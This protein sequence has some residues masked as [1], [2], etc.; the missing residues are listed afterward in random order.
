M[1]LPAQIQQFEEIPPK[2]EGDTPLLRIVAID[3]SLP[4]AA[5]CTTPFEFFIG[6]KGREKLPKGD[7]TDMNVTILIKEMKQGRVG[8]QCRGE[9]VKAGPFETTAPAQAAVQAEPAG[10]K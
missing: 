9:L 7:L 1:I 10:K 3:K 4:A 2:K 6:D 8:I 5:R